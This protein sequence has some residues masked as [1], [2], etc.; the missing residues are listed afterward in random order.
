MVELTGQDHRHQRGADRRR[1]LQVDMDQRRAAGDLMRRERLYRR[2]YQWHCRATQAHTHEQQ[3]CQEDRQVS[4]MCGDAVGEG[5][6]PGADQGDARQDHLARAALVQ[7]N[8]GD[9]HRQQRADPLGHHVHSGLQR[10]L[11]QQLLKAAR[12]QQCSPEKR[13][14]GK[15]KRRVSGRDL[16]VRE[17]PQVDQRV[18]AT[19][20]VQH[21]PADQRQPDGRRYPDVRIGD[22]PV[23]REG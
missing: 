15:Q 6:H 12:D 4:R 2:R 22:R 17:Q 5:G 16:P 10:G 7:Q 8:A 1:D 3:R 14:R 20:G 23:P 21:E 9:R 13:C 19:Q 11:L 18:L